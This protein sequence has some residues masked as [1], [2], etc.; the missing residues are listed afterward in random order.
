VAPPGGWD[1]SAES[2]R[3]KS[4]FVYGSG[5]VVAAVQLLR[6][7][8]DRLLLLMPLVPLLLLLLLVLLLLLLVRLLFVLLLLTCSLL[9][10]RRGEHYGVAVACGEFGNGSC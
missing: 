3:D 7:D 6:M 1:P 8:L 9:T 5:S 2:G 10:R 4:V